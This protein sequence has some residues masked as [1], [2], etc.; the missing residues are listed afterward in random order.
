MAHIPLP[1]APEHFC[2]EGVE[3][4][5]STVPVKPPFFAR[6]KST[7]YLP[8][9]LVLG[10]LSG[11]AVKNVPIQEWK[12]AREILLLG[13]SLKVAPVVRWDGQV[14]GDGRPGP[15]ARKLLAM[16]QADLRETTDQLVPVPYE[17][18]PIRV[19]AWHQASVLARV[20][21]AGSRNLTFSSVTMRSLTSSTPR[22][23]Q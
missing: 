3:L 1:F 15:I 21:C 22:R 6:V 11:I 8:N 19:Y 18:N 4:V 5:T 10:D 12:A 17:R 16:W 13:S 14:V 2:T 23:R 7:N 20:S 9:A